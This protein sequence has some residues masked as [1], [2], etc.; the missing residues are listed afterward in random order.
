MP[1]T[2]LEV[3]NIATRAL[4]ILETNMVMGGLVVRDLD[5]TYSK[6]GDTIQVRKPAVF[7][8]VEF[9]GD[10]S[11]EYQAATET[12]VDVK[13]DKILDVSVEVTS[14][15]M[16]LSLEDFTE[17]ITKPALATLAHKIDNY[18]TGLYVDIPYRYG[19]SGNTPDELKDISKIR[20]ILG[21]N[22]VPNS[23]RRL[24]IDTEAES[25]LGVLEQFTN[26]NFTGNTQGLTD[27]ALGKKMNFEIYTDQNVKTHVAGGY[28][29]LDDVTITTGAKDATS[30]VLTSD[31]GASTAKLVQGDLLTIDGVQYV[32]TA[33]TAAAAAG[34]V[35][36]AIYPALA[37]AFG[38]MDSVDVTFEDVTAGAHT[39]NIAF[40]ES[41]FALA[42]RPL[43]PAMGGAV[44]SA[45][46]AINNGVSVRVT[47]GYDMD[48]KKNKISFD[49]LVG[50]KTLYP[51]L[52]AI[53]LG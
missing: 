46:A 32:V 53:L 42:S 28:T 16:T 25:E 10:L 37:K 52:A 5:N 9:D 49:C 15:E 51:E 29:A 39:A 38:D 6:R 19:V 18:L 4:P 44:S 27:A 45:V 30:I 47:Y 11:G 35:T 14:K 43:M 3:K 40:H 20:K 12:S 41:A 21:D 50:V 22:K 13:L 24:V 26:S 31:A 17:Q 23:P 2:F 33:E 48:T 7:E 8:A 1:N 34:V 36:V